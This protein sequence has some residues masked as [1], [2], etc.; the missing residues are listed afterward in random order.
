MKYARAGSNFIISRNHFRD[1]DGFWCCWGWLGWICVVSVAWT[2][3]GQQ[4][5]PKITRSRQAK[6]Q[7][8][9]L[10][11]DAYNGGSGFEQSFNI[12]CTVASS[13]SSRGKKY[14]L[15]QT[16]IA[17][18]H[19]SV[20]PI[21]L[22]WCQH[23]PWNCWA[24]NGQ[25]DGQSGQQN[26]STWWTEPRKEGRENSLCINIV[27]LNSQLGQQHSHKAVWRKCFAGN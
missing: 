26:L 24:K 9:L 14:Y 20:L 25:R 3:L 4:T 7:I 19:V 18:H 1:P 12:M 10:F 16:E 2:G 23:D 15:D 21:G 11:S 17:C 8:Q 22:Y 27:L 13:N 6:Q 5:K